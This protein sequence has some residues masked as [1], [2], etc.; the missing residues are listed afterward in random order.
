MKWFIF[1]LVA[2]FGALLAAPMF[3][4][5]PDG[6]PIMSPDDWIPDRALERLV[7][8]AGGLFDKAERAG[9]LSPGGTAPGQQVYSWKDANGTVHYSDAPSE[10]AETVAIP[11]NSLEIP[12]KRFI[13]AGTSPALERRQGGAGGAVLLNDRDRRGGGTAAANVNSAELEAFVGGDYS[14][15]GAV[16]KNMP[17]ILEQA[18][19]ARA[20]DPA[21]R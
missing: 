10:G 11:D 7:E 15:A 3:I 14:K 6:K 5:G 21:T 16:L 18:K 19:Q 4:N 1:K 9:E 2:V 17:A 20:L 8:F 12:A 13:Q